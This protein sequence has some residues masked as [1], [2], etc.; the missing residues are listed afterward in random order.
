M[1]KAAVIGSGM[2]AETHLKSMLECGIEVT[3]LYSRNPAT[4]RALADR[5]RTGLYGSLDEVMESEGDLIV[6]CTPSGT[7]GTFSV[8]AMEHGKNVVTEKPAVLTEEDARRLLEAERRTGKI[9]APISQMRF[10]RSFRALKA[11][12]ERGDFGQI[13]LCVTT[14]Q[15]RRT[16][17]YFTVP[18]RGTKALDGGGVLMNQGI[19]GIDLICGL[20]GYPVRISGFAST[21]H[22]EIEVEDTAVA[23]LV[24]SCGALGAIS[25]TTAAGRPKPRR[26]ELSGTAASVVLEGSEIVAAEGIT[27]PLTDG[28]APAELPRTVTRTWEDPAAL[29]YDLHAA[30]YRNIAAALRGEE[31][32][33]YTAREAVNTVRVILE[34]YRSSET[35]RTLEF[36]PLC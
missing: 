36:Q 16:A 10:S 27:V 12:V 6:I 19:H 15:Y 14:M 29:N 17:E 7:H 11:A 18:W 5:Y 3:G 4:A 8:S 13:L 33:Y 31:P 26:L 9:C 32:L 2:I 24:F 23:S 1:L 20:L 25:A 30:Q 28:P 35:G 34:I 22:H 21:L